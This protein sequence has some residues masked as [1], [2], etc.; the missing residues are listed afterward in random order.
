[1]RYSLRSGERV[2]GYTDLDIE[3]ITPT[4]RQGFIE[5]TPEGRPLLADATGVWRAMAD[6]K[7]AQRARDGEKAAEDD[8]LV[9][10]AMS[11]RE[12]LNLELRDED[13]VILACAFM[14]VYDLFDLHAGVVDEMGD[15][16]EE[17]Q[18]DFEIYL[19]SLSQEDRAE[20]LTQRAETEAE[21]EAI[22]ADLLEQRD[23]EQLL[24]SSWPP[25]PREDPRWDTMQYQLQVYLKFSFEDE[26]EFPGQS[27]TGSSE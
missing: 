3:T 21:V 15:T 24:G 1:M 25:P 18:A 26:T 19:S 23:E 27:F 9:S 10:E 2:L 13:G 22:V 4:M 8:E 17:Q 16:E 5:P 12:A 6:R 14:R 20:A 7:R 11:R